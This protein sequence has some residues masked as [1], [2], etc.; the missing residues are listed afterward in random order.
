MLQC[1]FLLIRDAR[2][3]IRIAYVWWLSTILYVRQVI[4]RLDKVGK[5]ELPKEASVMMLLSACMA[6]SALRR[7]TKRL[8]RLSTHYQQLAKRISLMGKSHF[9]ETCCSIEGFHVTINVRR[10]RRT[11]FDRF[12]WKDRHLDL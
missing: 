4:W 9:A 1:L 7:Y 2:P 3:F 12:V 5:V 10:A 6:Q 11:R 8:P